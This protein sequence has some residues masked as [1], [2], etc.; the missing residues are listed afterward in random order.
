MTR[1]TALLIAQLGLAIVGAGCV[2][3]FPRRIP[4]SDL[5]LPESPDRTAAAGLLSRCRAADSVGTGRDP[6][7]PCGRTAGDSTRSTSDPL[8]PPVQKTP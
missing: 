3:G 6:G 7:T 5:T 4:G 8:T 1:Q 2:N